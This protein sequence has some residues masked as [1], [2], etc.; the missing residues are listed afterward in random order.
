[1]E[2]WKSNSEINHDGKTKS[3]FVA[4]RNIT[5]SDDINTK[6]LSKKKAFQ[7]KKKGC[8]FGDI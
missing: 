6:L 7:A 2:F 4:E 5:T 1:M 3:S 8:R